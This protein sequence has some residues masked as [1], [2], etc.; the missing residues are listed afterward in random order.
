MLAGGSKTNF[1]NNL[2]T[3]L[4]VIFKACVN[5]CVFC[6]MRVI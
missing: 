6:F 1:V 2:Y 3:K 4:L 5:T